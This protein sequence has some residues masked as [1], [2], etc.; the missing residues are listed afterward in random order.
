MPAFRGV[1]RVVVVDRPTYLLTGHGTL[2]VV[3]AR[4]PEPTGAR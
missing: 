2:G 4:R 1:R 3:V